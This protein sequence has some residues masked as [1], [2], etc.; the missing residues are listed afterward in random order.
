M[1]SKQTQQTRAATP[2]LANESGATLRGAN[3]LLLAI[4]LM[5]IAA[6]SALANT[7][8][9]AASAESPVVDTA[10]TI[11]T[12]A[13]LPAV[14]TTDA[15]PGSGPTLAVPT[16]KREVVNAM[17]RDLSP[18][19]MFVAADS[20]VKIVMVFLVAASLLS[21][22]VCAAKAMEI[23]AEYR[24][25]GAARE[26][27]QAAKS[28]A[29]AALAVEPIGGVG[30]MLVSAAGNECALSG[31]LAPGGIKERTLLAMTQIELATIRRMRTGTGALATIGAI[32]PFLGL[33]GTIWGIMN[34]FIGISHAQTTNLA[35]V[36][37]GIAEALL[38]TALGLFAAIPAVVIYNAVTRAI[39][40]HRATLND[41]STDIV[42]LV[43]RDL[44]RGELGRSPNSA[45]R[46]AAARRT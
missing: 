27:L 11:E 12:I 36:A 18:W 22:T 44:D 8:L 6:I 21:W 45:G 14:A 2:N 23:R 37:P 15:L 9:Y 3:R 16:A 40:G 1:P 17:P 41:L 7:P 5:A 19:G 46:A 25:V 32:A 39:A 38:A 26:A 30:A 43:G 20:V 42:R 29:A 33:F 24:R 34:S 35:V 4:L 13:K 10:S 31:G 28:F